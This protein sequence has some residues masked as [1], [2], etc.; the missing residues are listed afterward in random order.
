MKT[1]NSK[2]EKKTTKEKKI[3]LFGVRRQHDRICWTREYLDDR[4]S[5][6]YSCHFVTTV[7]SY[8]ISDEKC[9]W[10]LNLFFFSIHF[11]HISKYPPFLLFLRHVIIRV[12]FSSVFSIFLHFFRQFFILIV[13]HFTCS[14]FVL[15]TFFFQY[16][17]FTIHNFALKYENR[18]VPKMDW[19]WCA[20]LFF[21]FSFLF[22]SKL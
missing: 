15:F 21:F 10:L 13:F 4:V 19:S 5:R 1:N 8:S 18:S 14:I 16:I 2:K 9:S 11:Y 20:I 3:K 7:L 12:F 22:V 17:F 6:K